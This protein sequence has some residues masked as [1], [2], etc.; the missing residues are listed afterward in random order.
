MDYELMKNLETAI[1]A[2]YKSRFFSQKGDKIY[3]ITTDQIACLV[4]E[5]GFVILLDKDKRKFVLQH[6]LDVLE[7][8]IDPLDFFRV[9]RKIIVRYDSMNNMKLY[10]KGRIEFKIEGLEEII[11]VSRRRNVAFK[12]WLDK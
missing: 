6:S 11:V 8:L 1:S 5:D 3:T 10:P 2:K 9:N 12:K 7:T 4:F